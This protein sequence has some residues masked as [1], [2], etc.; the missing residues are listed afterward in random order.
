M[1]RSKSIFPILLALSFLFD[2]A[3]GIE[4]SCIIPWICY[5][6]KNQV[7]GYAKVPQ[8]QGQSIARTHKLDVED[9]TTSKQ[10]GPGFYMLSEPIWEEEERSWYCVI[11]ANREKM[12]KV[13]KAWIPRHYQQT[14][15]D[16][17]TVV[18]DLWYQNDVEII[19]DYI[20]YQVFIPAA[21]KALRFSWVHE[22]G[23]WQ[24]QMTIPENVAKNDDLG[25]WATCFPTV[26]DLKRYTQ[27]KV[28]W[29]DEWDI[30]VGAV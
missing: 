8:A 3:F 12:R 5:A 4:T 14:T 22:G 17:E 24:E 16:G 25:I 30:E 19:Y 27:E 7:I 10:V 13:S 29:T 18:K 1:L 26:W 23:V 9:S 11:K 2:G 28:R 6:S 20:S 21:E 15:E